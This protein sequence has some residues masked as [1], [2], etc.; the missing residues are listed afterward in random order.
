M[1]WL[2]LI[3]A[4][5]VT[6]AFGLCE[7]IASQVMRY[8]LEANQGP[9]RL[10]PS[11]EKG[12]VV[13]LGDAQ[14]WNLRETDPEV[15]LPFVHERPHETQS[16]IVSRSSEEVWQVVSRGKHVSVEQFDLQTGNKLHSQPWHGS[17]GIPYLLSENHLLVAL[18]PTFAGRPKDRLM[19]IR[20]PR[21]LRRSTL[22]AEPTDGD[23]KTVLLSP[24]EKII[25]MDFAKGEGRFVDALTGETLTSISGGW[26]S[27]A[28][29]PDGKHFAAAY[30]SGGMEIF[31]VR[32]ISVAAHL[33][34]TR[35]EHFGQVLFHPTRESTFLA[36]QADK[37]ELWK[38][39]SHFTTSIGR[40]EVSESSII[41]AAI[42]ADGKRMATSLLRGGIVVWDTDSLVPL[43]YLRGAW[44]SA[45]EIYF[46][47]DGSFLVGNTLGAEIATWKLPTETEIDRSSQVWST[48]HV[49]VLVTQNQ[50]AR[51]SVVF[52]KQ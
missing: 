51:K 39:G 11:R 48:D 50:G 42:S 29:S 38:M 41:A 46:S 44:R 21:D 35:A 3:L 12:L 9:G 19:E 27:G 2:V 17:D 49:D 22:I 4:L 23:L 13:V 33:K 52:L 31:D 36:V 1:K 16:V 15:L 6:P 10:L 37:A 32:Q 7:I 47:H 43:F 40:I 5:G 26:T 24:D 14:I 30:E 20:N 45:H 8:D 34:S 28:F 25:A 18:P